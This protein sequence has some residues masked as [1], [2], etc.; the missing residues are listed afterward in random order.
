MIKDL[1]LEFVS[2]SKRPLG[3]NRIIIIDN[4]NNIINTEKIIKTNLND[5]DF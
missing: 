4:E 5:F 3:L 1:S 2:K